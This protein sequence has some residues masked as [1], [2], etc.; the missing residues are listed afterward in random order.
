MNRPPR[1][2]PEDNLPSNRGGGGMRGG[3]GRPVQGQDENQFEDQQP[4][5]GKLGITGQQPRRQDKPGKFAHI[6]RPSRRLN[7]IIFLFLVSFSIIWVTWTMSDVTG[8]YQ[9]SGYE[10]EV[11]RLSMLRLATNVKCRL[12][13]GSGATMEAT[14]NKID[15][16]KPLYIEFHTPAKWVSAGRRERTVILDGKFTDNGSNPLQG[17]FQENEIKA[18][19]IENNQYVNVRLLRNSVASLWRQVQAHWPWAEI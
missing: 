17:S 11:V 7:V 15:T 9:S 13:W 1:R 5:L 3:Q 8:E 10:R 16:S 12:N 19:L 2:R 18:R 6:I 14:V 4:L